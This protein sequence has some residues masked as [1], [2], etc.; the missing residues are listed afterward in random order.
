MARAQKTIVISLGGSI[1]VP[2]R[3][4]VEF[5]KK[6]KEFILKFLKQNYRFV[7]VVGGG[8]IARQYQDAAVKI[9]NISAED[10]D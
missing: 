7:V 6:F 10:R 1:I 2:G 9:S 4:Q 5:L 8:A 3:I